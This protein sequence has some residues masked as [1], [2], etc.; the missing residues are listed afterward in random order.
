MKKYLLLVLFGLITVS[1]KAQVNVRPMSDSSVAYKTLSKEYPQA[2]SLRERATLRDLVFQKLLE[3]YW[4]DFRRFLKKRNFRPDSSIIWNTEVFFRADGHADWLL[5]QYSQFS[6]P[7]T[8]LPK[9]KEQTLITLLTEYLNQHALPVS[10]RYVWSPFRLGGVLIITGPSS[11]KLPKGRGVI[12]DL[13]SANQTTRPDTVKTISFGGLELEQV[14]DVIYRFTNVEE[15][16][17]GGNYLTSLPAKVTAL[18]KLQR[19]NLLSNRLTEDSLFFTRNKVVKS[20]NLQRNSLTGIPASISQNR[21]LESLWLGNNDLVDLNL[22][23]LHSL[24]QLND[25]NL[26]NV[27]L[28]QIPKT[29]G[30]LK[31]VKVLDL[32]YNKFTELPRQLGR[33]KRLE[34]LAIAHNNLKEIP[35]SFAKLRRLQVLYAHHNHLNQLPTKLKRLQRL[36]VLDL[37]YNELIT[38]PSVLGA[39]SGLEELSL[40]NNNLQDFPTVL[41]SLKNL[42]H[43][44]MSSNPLW[45]R[46]AMSSPYASQIKQLEANNTEV[47]Y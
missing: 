43:V 47:K 19:L 35:V 17:L 14:P 5:Y 11:R 7:T 27:G 23:P 42:K 15:I 24:R 37:G 33:M 32:Y 16:H 26:Y 36:H 8:R 25:L 38:A 44:Y 29:I 30:R 9:E 3:D 34:Q 20:I 12:G 13:A 41:L 39:L 21:R 2:V 4:G 28:T 40:N 6:R 22:K 1:G 31:H 18:P 46:E 45:G 10:S